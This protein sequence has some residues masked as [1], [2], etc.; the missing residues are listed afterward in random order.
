MFN[1]DFFTPRTPM[2]NEIEVT[3]ALS[4]GDP[5]AYLAKD[6]LDP[7]MASF[8]V[9]YM[10]DHVNEPSKATNIKAARFSDF[11][12]LMERLS[13]T[14]PSPAELDAAPLLA[15]WCAGVMDPTP[16]LFG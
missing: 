2:L 8:F 6:A 12:D 11:L 16:R 15:T 4:Q 14:P 3:R 10:K 9:Q 5:E 7:V 1:D 13:T